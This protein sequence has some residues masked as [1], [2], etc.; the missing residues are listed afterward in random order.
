MYSDIDYK[1]IYSYNYKTGDL[2]PDAT[3]ELEFSKP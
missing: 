3:T 1:I 2:V